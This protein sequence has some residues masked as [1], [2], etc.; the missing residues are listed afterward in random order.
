MTS[1]E[2]EKYTDSFIEKVKSEI[3]TIYYMMPYEVVSEKQQD[4]LGLDIYK[5]LEKNSKKYQ[6]V[7]FDH[8]NDLKDFTNALKEYNNLL[9][10]LLSLIIDIEKI[11]PKN[12]ENFINI[13][14]ILHYYA[15][16]IE[17]RNIDLVRRFFL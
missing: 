6:D 5:F 9:N 10:N 15:Q 1:I 11:V 17:K 3:I 8:L 13:K 14:K 12:E 7:N 4:I 16:F 2:S